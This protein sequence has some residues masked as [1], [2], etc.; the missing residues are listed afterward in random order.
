MDGAHGGA[1]QEIKVFLLLFL[2]KKKILFFSGSRAC[3]G[4]APF[5]V[6]CRR[7][8]YSKADAASLPFPGPSAAA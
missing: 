7:R 5:I 4:A 6:S 2:Q 8:K 3:P 1:A